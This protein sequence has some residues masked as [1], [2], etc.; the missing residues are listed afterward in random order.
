MNN[1]NFQKEVMLF[2]EQAYKRAMSEA[3]KRGKEAAK[4]KR[5]LVHSPCK[6]K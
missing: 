4:K 1:K 2:L 3:I 6:R 5:L